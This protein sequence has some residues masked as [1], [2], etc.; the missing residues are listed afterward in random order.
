MPEVSRYR[1][2]QHYGK[3][4]TIRN[5]I[6]AANIKGQLQATRVETHL[7][8]NFTSNI[9]WYNSGNLLVNNWSKIN[10][11]SDSNCYWDTRTNDIRFNKLSF[12]EWQLSGK[13]KKS[14]VANPEFVN[15]ETFDFTIKNKAMIRKI[16]FKPFD[17]SK[18]GV[19]GSEEWIKLS[20]FDQV[21]AEKYDKVVKSLVNY[22]AIKN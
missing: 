3:E 12:K 4:N 6:F 7:S 13:D 11:N 14:V 21:L 20:K 10:I 2:H 9:I 17:Y 16:G 1:F 15:P 19:Y 18:A 22:A 8:F 5:N